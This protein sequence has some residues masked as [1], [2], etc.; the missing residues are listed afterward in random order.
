MEAWPSRVRKNATS[1][2]RASVQS[3]G[4]GGTNAHVILETARTSPLIKGNIAITHAA[5]VEVQ[6]K[7]QKPQ[8]FIFTAKATKSLSTGIKELKDWVYLNRDNISL[9]DLAHTL[10]N[11]R[12]LMAWRSTCVAY[13]VHDL[14][15]SM[16][17]LRATRAPLSTP[18]P[19]VFLFTGQGA[20]W[21]AMGRELLQMDGAFRDSII[22]SEDVL[23]SLGLTWRLLDELQKDGTVS[24][25]SESEVAQIAS[26]AIQ[27]ALIDLLQVLQV[28]PEAVVGHSSGEIAAAYAVGALSRKDAMIISLCRSQIDR[29]CREMLSMSGAMMAVGLGEAEVLPYVKQSNQEQV[30]C[31][32]TLLCV[33][34]PTKTNGH[35]L[36]Q[37][38]KT[39]I[40]CINSP[41]STT[42]T[43]DREAVEGLQKVFEANSIFSRLLKVDTA[44]HSHHM[45]V[46]AL[47][48]EQAL[49]NSKFHVP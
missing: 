8:L 37:R 18:P 12:S 29:W 1:V 34:R 4:F 17:N 26:T 16:G 15:S 22:K 14:L 32:S 49:G 27:V 28:V 31:N 44:Y 30:V 25:I 13:S 40:A 45:E 38:S 42:I 46:V 39:S 43:G 7:A 48:Y 5:H 3:F 6:E 20:Q 24:R 9:Q 33:E 2:R 10:S 47:R 23:N 36:L 11:R 35:Y 41:V 21:F 19:V